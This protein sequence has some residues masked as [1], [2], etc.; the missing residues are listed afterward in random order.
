M[1]SARTA[2]SPTHGGKSRAAHQKP[3]NGVCHGVFVCCFL[4]RL[5]FVGKNINMILWLV[6]D[7]FFCGW[8]TPHS[9][10][11]HFSPPF[12]HVPFPHVPFPHAPLLT[13][14]THPTERCWPWVRL[15][16]K[17]SLYWDKTLMPMV[18]ICL[19]LQVMGVVDVPIRLQTCC[20]MCM[21]CQVSV[22]GV[23]CSMCCV[24]GVV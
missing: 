8:Y 1:K 5:F 11:S 13:C 10:T 17:K 23:V 15:G 4:F 7:V 21:M 12:P 3:S 18:G 16:I 6:Y 19:V 22:G 2:L 9:H 24:G 14:T 20:V